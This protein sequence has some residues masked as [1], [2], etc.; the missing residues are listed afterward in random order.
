MEKQLFLRN[1]VIPDEIWPGPEEDAPWDKLPTEYTKKIKRILDELN[2]PPTS[3]SSSSGPIIDEGPKIAYKPKLAFNTD[4]GS[5]SEQS[6]PIRF[7]S[8]GSTFEEE[9]V[10][11]QQYDPYEFSQKPW[12]DS[13][14]SQTE[15]LARL[16]IS[17]SSPEITQS[18][19]I[20]Y[21][22]T[23]PAT[24]IAPRPDTQQLWFTD[25]DWE[26]PQCREEI[27]RL[28]DEIEAIHVA[29]QAHKAEEER[30]KKIHRCHP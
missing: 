18:C 21:D 14:Y 1:R 24:H 19:K 5:S 20:K 3:P 2:S 7:Q 22:L 28:I 8:E 29:E 27:L 13:D 11:Y 16:G 9:H 6:Q 15:N 4:T 30:A 25:E 10:L 12:P 23:P 26:D 17:V